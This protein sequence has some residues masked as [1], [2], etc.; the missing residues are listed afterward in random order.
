ML[1]PEW[2]WIADTRLYLHGVLFSVDG[3]LRAWSSVL[4][5]VQVELHGLVRHNQVSTLHLGLDGDDHL[6]CRGEERGRQVSLGHGDR[7]TPLRGGYWIK[8]RNMYRSG[9]C[10]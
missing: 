4:P 7:V 10:S 1:R 8:V 6:N 3:V 5:P 2:C 9:R